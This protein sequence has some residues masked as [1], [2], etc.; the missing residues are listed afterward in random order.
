MVSPS[1]SRPQTR[2]EDDEY[3]LSRIHRDGKAR[4]LV[5]S[6]FGERPETLA[7][8]ERAYELR[9]VLDPAWATRPLSLVRRD[10]GD[11]LLLEDPRGEVLSTL[12]V[13]PW[14]S[15]TFLRVAIGIA[16]ALRQLH[17]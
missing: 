17:K 1:G 8:L 9:E 14:E 13:R 11:E 5:R 7:R 3:V 10:G 16:A 12:V 2:W 4:L 6:R 15:N